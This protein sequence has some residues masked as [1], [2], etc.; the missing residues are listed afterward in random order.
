MLESEQRLQIQNNVSKQQ[1]T[2]KLLQIISYYMDVFA[3]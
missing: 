3:I 2:I 1:L